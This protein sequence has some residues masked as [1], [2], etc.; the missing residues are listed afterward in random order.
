LGCDN[1][2]LA[3]DKLTAFYQHPVWIL[4]G[5]FSEQDEFSRGHREAIAQWIANNPISRV[6]D[7]GGGMGTLAR[8][9]IHKNPNIAIDIYEPYPHP[10]ALKQCQPH[11][12]IQ[13]I[14]TIEGT[15]YD[16][17]VSLDVLEHVPDP[18]N[19]LSEMVRSVKPGGYLIIANHFF[20][21][22]KCHLPSTFHLRYSFDRFAAM[23]GLRSLGRCE[24]SHATIYQKL[25]DQE[26]NWQVIRARETLSK[27][28]F[29]LR[30]FDARYLY[31]WKSRWNRLTTNPRKTC[32]EFAQKLVRSHS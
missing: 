15:S 2:V 13:F 17:L 21:S 5:L 9:I 31:P 3:A 27:Q 28:L 18:L 7:F 6:I 20:P 4:N 26:I 23:M 32:Q 30:E 16:C 10:F 14:E 1:R 19:L 8:M 11:N 29:P 25:Q 12:N 24:G 22:I